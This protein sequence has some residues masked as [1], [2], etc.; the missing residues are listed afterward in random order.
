M[1]TPDHRDPNGL[2][3]GIR[4]PDGSSHAAHLAERERQRVLQRRMLNG[5]PVSP[6]EELGITVRFPP[7]FG[8]DRARYAL[9]DR[10]RNAVLTQVVCLAVAPGHSLLFLDGAVLREGD[11][12]TLPRLENRLDA[13]AALVAR[14][15]LLSIPGDAAFARTIPEH[16]EH[17]C[18]AEQLQGLT[19][20]FHRGDSVRREDFDLP[21]S[22]KREPSIQEI[23]DARID[24]RLGR[25]V[26]GPSMSIFDELLSSRKVIRNPRF[27]PTKDAA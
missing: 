16:I 9:E 27:R 20:T 1:A 17:A 23:I 8:D 3:G 26:T 21:P 13:R 4:W 19:R 11:E 5:E 14:G 22:K 10:T 7:T 25:A 15:V 2:I 24:V 12:V 6:I 18:Y